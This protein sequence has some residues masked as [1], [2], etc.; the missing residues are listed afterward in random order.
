MA[1]RLGLARV[2]AVPLVIARGG[3][4]KAVGVLALG[5]LPDAAPAAPVPGLLDTVADLAAVAIDRAQLAATAAEQSEWHERLAHIDP[6]TGLANRRTFDR[7]LELELARAGRQGSEV[8]VLAFDVDAFRET[9][10]QAGRGVGDAILRAV[11]AILAEQVRLVDTVARIGG[12][13][14]VIVAPGSGGLAVAT[15]VTDAIHRL[16]PVDGVP[17]SVSTGIARFPQDGTSGEAMLEAA[18]A[19]LVAA[20]DAGRGAIAEAAPTS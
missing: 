6:L 15:R 16:E 10:A 5:W 14:F 7:V 1:A 19:A 13:E 4:D 18:L 20:R 12:D 9:N 3:I 8:A 17:I 11:A 2:R